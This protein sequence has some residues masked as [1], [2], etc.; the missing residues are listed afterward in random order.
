MHMSTHSHSLGKLSVWVYY[1]FAIIMLC[2]SVS[3]AYLKWPFPFS[4]T[5]LHRDRE[6][7]GNVASCI[8]T[9]NFQEFANGKV[10]TFFINKIKLF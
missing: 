7:M 4:F 2:T 5:M 1:H 9:Y 10:I 6:R 8:Q 3:N